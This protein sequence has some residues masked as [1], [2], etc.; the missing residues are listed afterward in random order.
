MK[1]Y[2]SLCNRI[3]ENKMYVS[4]IEVGTGMTEYF[5]SDR[6]PYEVV[7]VISQKHVKVRKYDYKCIGG[8]ASNEWQLISNEQNWIGEL[9]F[10]Y[11]SWY[12]VDVNK[13]TNKIEYRKANVSFGRAEK[14]YD[15]EF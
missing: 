10:R 4:T 3:E 7:E 15:Y 11:G 1:A 12:W 8:F 5:W 9:K 14:Y 6:E 2:G 13:Y